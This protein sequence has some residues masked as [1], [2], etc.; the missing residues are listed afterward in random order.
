MV[1]YWTGPYIDVPEVP[2]DDSKH[3]VLA[4]YVGTAIHVKKFPNYTTSHIFRLII[5]EPESG[6]FFNSKPSYEAITVSKM[7][8]R[9]VY[10]QEA[11]HLMAEK[12]FLELSFTEEYFESF[13]AYDPED[14]GTKP[15]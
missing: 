2:S 10:F 12:D 15:E 5:Y 11:R 6:A 7:I 13:E 1:A 9:V 4:R 3:L 8:D 14:D